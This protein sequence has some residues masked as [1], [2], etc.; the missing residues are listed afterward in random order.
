MNKNY[1]TTPRS[2]AI[3]RALWK[4]CGADRYI[5]EKSTYSD[6]IKYACLGGIVVATGVLA[7]IAGGYAFYTIF[8]PKGSAIDSSQI[9]LQTLILST[10]F[11]SIWGLIIF[12]I[13]RFIVTSTG[14]GDGTEAITLQEMKS[15]LPRIIM[16]MIIALTISKP[17]EIRMFQ[18][19]INAELFSMQ[20][21]VRDTLNNKTNRK[22]RLLIDEI[23]KEDSKLKAE[24]VDLKTQVEGMQQQYIDE[25]RIITV[26]PRA[27][28]VKAEMEKLE[29]KQKD[30]ESKNSPRIKELSIK[31][32][33]LRKDRNKEYKTNEDQAN[34]L[35]GLLERIKL[36]HKLA[37]TWISL[38][39]TLLFMAIELTPIF[40]K[41]MLIK[42]PYDY[43]EQ[44]IKELM[45][46]EEGI[47]VQYDYYQDKHGVEKDLVTFHKADLLLHEKMKLIEAQK[48]LSTDII[49]K[50]KEKERKNISNN[51]DDYIIKG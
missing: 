48:E 41:L 14:K 33:A 13:D 51:P 47:Q 43:L 5:L 6:H 7:A 46:A 39:I 40:F 19:E 28:A 36:A 42:S 20:K 29:A 45:K 49:D 4:A 35:D 32:E 26:G 23:E 12:N 34:A 10:F 50:W 11:G 3:I 22:F 16:G 44:N 21:D 37:G 18:S 2:T 24:I 30:V 17:V 9:H 15:A 1:Y 27:L 25:A 38:F 31:L 8:Q